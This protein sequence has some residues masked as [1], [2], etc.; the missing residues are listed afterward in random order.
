MILE[1]CGHKSHQSFAEYNVKVI[2]SINKSKIDLNNESICICNDNE[3]KE[4]FAF[5]LF[6]CLS[7][8]LMRIT[9]NVA[10]IIINDVI[11]D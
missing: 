11:N 8:T 3:L 7:F 1:F 2:I 5:I 9:K 4:N 6:C 10:K